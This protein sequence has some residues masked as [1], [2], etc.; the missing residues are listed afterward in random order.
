[1]KEIK[2]FFRGHQSEVIKHDRHCFFCHMSIFIKS[3]DLIQCPFS[4]LD[5]LFIRIKCYDYEF[6][7][8]QSMNL[9][10]NKEKFKKILL[11]NIYNTHDNKLFYFYK[12]FRTTSICCIQSFFHKGCYDFYNFN[13]DKLTDQL[14]VR[15][16][17]EIEK[18]KRK[19]DEIIKLIKNKI[20]SCLF[21]KIKFNGS[22]QNLY[23]S[24][25]NKKVHKR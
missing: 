22:Y 17:K 5:Y 7:L 19:E 3:L 10:I 23:R 14:S 16:N 8:N 24:E 20:I 21:N 18:F 12:K 25:Y 15:K 9:F 4:L 13:E 11:N 2:I 6:F 1:M